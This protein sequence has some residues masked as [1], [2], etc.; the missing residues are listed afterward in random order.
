MVVEKFCDQ[1]GDWIDD[2]ECGGA[3]NVLYNRSKWL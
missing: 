3:K 2:E 1:R